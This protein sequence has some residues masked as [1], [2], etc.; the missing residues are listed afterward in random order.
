MAGWRRFLV[1]PLVI[2]YS[3]RAPRDRARVW[4]TYWGSIGGGGP[5][6]D[7][8]WD[9]AT[10]RDT[11]WCADRAVHHFDPELPVVDVA[12]GNGTQALVLAEHFAPV[13]GVDVS[14]EAITRARQRAGGRAGVSFRVADVT[15][16]GAGRALAAE[17]GPAN[18]HIRG[19]L[20]ILTDRQRDATAAN[21]ADL[22]GERGVVLLAETAAA[23]GALRYLDRLG[24]RVTAFPQT[25]A[26]CLR[27]GLPIP[28][29]FGDR[30]LARTFPADRWEVLASGATDLGVVVTGGPATVPAF[31]AVLRRRR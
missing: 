21:L 8:L 19:L 11:R 23:G 4:D 24:V 29:D 25:V 1:L 10:D 16:P 3:M 2:W 20:H 13:V 6:G 9:A 26:R 5:H 7:V 31:Y 27:A 30:E 12:C 14:A 28:R 18:V 17:I 15:A 22:V